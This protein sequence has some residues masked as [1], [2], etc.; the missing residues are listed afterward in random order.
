[1]ARTKPKEHKRRRNGQCYAACPVCA[2]KR[3]ET[4]VQSLQVLCAFGL[5]CAFSAGFG[6]GIARMRFSDAV[7][8]KLAQS[9]PPPFRDLAMNSPVPPERKNE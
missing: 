8:M 2:P 1:M 7:Y 3:K 5:K 4:Y 9:L 6:Y